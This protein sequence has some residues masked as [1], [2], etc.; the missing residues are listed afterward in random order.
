MLGL[1]R[2]PPSFNVVGG[3]CANGYD[4]RDGQSW[5]YFSAYDNPLW[6]AYNNPLTGDVDRITGNISGTV[7][8]M[9]WLDVTGRIGTDAYSDNRKQIFAVGAQDPPA[10]VGEIWENTKHH[11]EVNA[12]LFASVRPQLE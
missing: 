2:M 8:L 7:A 11:L 4:T 3:P 12:D 1:T 10:P 5:T 9:P 6:S